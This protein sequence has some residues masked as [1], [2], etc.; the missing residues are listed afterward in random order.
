MTTPMRSGMRRH[1]RPAA[2][3]SKTRRAESMAYGRPGSRSFSF[4]GEFPDMADQQPVEAYNGRRNHTAARTAG[5]YHAVRH[6]DMNHMP[7]INKYGVH[8]VTAL[9]MFAVIF[10]ILGCIVFTQLDERSNVIASIRARQERIS[11]LTTQCADTRT[12]IAAQSNDVNIRQEA[13]RM[14]LISSKGVAVQY[15]QAPQDAVITLKD[16][17]A[18]QSLASIWGQ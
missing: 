5:S 10:V 6:D 3:V 17:T 18:I 9:A 4:T 13:V 8:F 1:T 12:K 15:L 14:G 11:E 16:Q 2:F 7:V